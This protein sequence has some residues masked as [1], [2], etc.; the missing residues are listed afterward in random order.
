MGHYDN[1]YEAE[2]KEFQEKKEKDIKNDFDKLVKKLTLDD[3]NFLNKIMRNI[4]DYKALDRL[5]CNKNK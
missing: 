3:K 5:L 2:E 4:E 1:C